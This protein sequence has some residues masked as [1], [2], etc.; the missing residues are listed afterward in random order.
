MCVCVYIYIYINTYRL[1]QG[2]KKACRQRIVLIRVS[3]ISP[4]ALYAQ[5]LLVRHHAGRP[6]PPVNKQS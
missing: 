2:N 6:L 1:T 5:V 4:D 3:P